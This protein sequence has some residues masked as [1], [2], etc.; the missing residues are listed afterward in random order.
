MLYFSAKRKNIQRARAPS[1]VLC[2]KWHC[3]WRR[4]P[5]A[6]RIP[7][8]VC[9]RRRG[10]KCC[11]RMAVAQLARTRKSSR[12]SRKRISARISISLRTCGAGASWRR[13]AARQARVRGAA[14]AAARGRRAWRAAARVRSRSGTRSSAGGATPAR[15]PRARPALDCTHARE[16]RVSSGAHCPIGRRAHIA[17]AVAVACCLRLW[18]R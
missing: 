7:R 9:G 18:S 13:A 1:R 11:D 4:E 16:Q 6:R 17:I 2:R 3:G 15:T 8:C 12:C 10:Q 5:A 14:S